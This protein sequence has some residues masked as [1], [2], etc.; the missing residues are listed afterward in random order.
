MSEVSLHQKELRR[1]VIRAKDFHEHKFSD[2]TSNF[3]LVKSAIR[4]YSVK[5]GMSIT[6]TRI[7][8]DFPLAVTIAGSCLSLLEELEVVE[9]RSESSSADRYPPASVDLE[10]LE[11]IEEILVESNEIG[12]FSEVGH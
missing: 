2:L 11:V 6:S 3:Y 5:K 7:S 10:R 4:Y 9:K 8:E 1:E 12:S